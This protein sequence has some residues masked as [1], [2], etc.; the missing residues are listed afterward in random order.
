[1]K[2]S[3]QYLE[4]VADAQELHTSLIR[5]KRS[6]K[7][8]NQNQQQLRAF[9]GLVNYYGKFLPSLSGTAYSLNRLLQNNSKWIWSKTCETAFRILKQQLSSKPVLAHY[10]LSLLLKLECDASPYRVGHL[11]LILCQIEIKPHHIWV[12]NII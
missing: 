1:M 3:V 12:K 8:H 2:Q 10:D 5:S 6:K 4:H 11:F 9:L 7:Q